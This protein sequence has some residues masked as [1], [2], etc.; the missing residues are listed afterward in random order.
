MPD[1]PTPQNHA[2]APQIRPANERDID[3]LYALEQASFSGDR[4]SRRRFRHWVRADNR[5]F[6][7][8]EQDHQLLGYVLVLLRRGTRL[9]RLYSL[10]VGPAGRGKGIGKALLTSAEDASS[11]SGRLYM[12]LEVAEQNSP[13]IALYQQLGY[14]T[15][16]SYAN[17]YEDAG[18]ALRMQKRIRYRPENLHT[19]EVPWYGQR[20]E[21][22]CGPAAAMMAMAGLDPQYEPSGSDELAL[23]REATTIFMT[24]GTGGCHPIG[25]AL[26][27]Q[28]RGFECEVYL[29]QRGPLFIS[30]V[31]SEKKKRV[32]E[33]VDGDFRSCATRSG[34]SVIEQD[35]T[36]Q[37]CEQ[38]LTEGALVLLLISTFRLDGKKV[39]HWVTLTGMDDECFYLHDPDVD[40]EDNP[41]DSQYLPIAREDISR[42]SIFGREKLRTAVIVRR[43]D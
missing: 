21:F 12:R 8:A 15:F 19:A 20:T 2:N 32:I 39:P 30:S 3:A 31:R 14:R 5:V 38:W 9:A 23:W 18:N 1:H 25:L 41:L 28:K 4:L 22:T 36:Q 6:L 11:R 10:A 35:F 27:M 13:A 43:K 16:G 26:A 24:S 7:V 42:M 33:Q 29:N 40:D 17:Y 37:Q 34:L